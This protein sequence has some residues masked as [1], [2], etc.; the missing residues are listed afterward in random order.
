MEG[1]WGLG[2]IF[3]FFFYYS[4]VSTQSQLSFLLLLIMVVVIYPIGH[5]V[6]AKSWHRVILGEGRDSF[7][8]TQIS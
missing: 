5:M 2:L 1:F 3:F 4:F 7:K 6:A 8:S